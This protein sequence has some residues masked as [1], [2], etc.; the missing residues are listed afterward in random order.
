MIPFLLK[1]LFLLMQHTGQYLVGFVLIRPQYVCQPSVEF[2]HFDGSRMFK[3]DSRDGS[4]VRVRVLVV[5]V[6]V[7]MMV[8][9]LSVLV[10]LL[11]MVMVM[12][13]VMV[14]MVVV[15]GGSVVLAT[16][17]AI[18]IIAVIVIVTVAVIGCECVRGSARI[19]QTG[20][21][22][23]QVIKSTK[24]IGVQYPTEI[25]NLG[26]GCV[27]NWRRGVDPADGSFHFEDTNITAGR[28]CTFGCI[29]TCC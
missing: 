15:V 1:F 16:L 20:F 3:G 12:V 9:M 13:M 10:F 5:F 25:R 4:R 22:L 11:V 24:A 27:Q 2:F 28:T 18:V 21:H 26:K 6:M 7:M 29:C 14:S 23:L 8:L 17:G 19:F